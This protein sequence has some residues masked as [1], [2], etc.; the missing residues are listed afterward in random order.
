M[1]AEKVFTIRQTKI[2][3]IVSKSKFSQKLVHDI[4]LSIFSVGLNCLVMHALTFQVF[5][6]DHWRKL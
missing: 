6:L 4:N 3:E 2:F 1:D 5:R